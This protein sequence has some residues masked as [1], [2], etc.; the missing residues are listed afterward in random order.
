MTSPIQLDSVEQPGNVLHAGA[1]NAVLEFLDFFPTS[2]QRS[3]ATVAS[4]VCRGISVESFDEFVQPGLPRVTQLLGNTD[5]RIVDSAILCFS[6][7]VDSISGDDDKT[8]TV[9]TSDLIKIIVSL[10]S[11]SS[12]SS[13]LSGAPPASSSASS[14]AVGPSSVAMIFRMLSVAC[15]TSHSIISL[16]LQSDIAGILSTAISAGCS[17]SSDRAERAAADPKKSPKGII[18]GAGGGGVGGGGGGGGGAVESNSQEKLME[19]LGL[20]NELLPP[21][22]DKLEIAFNQASKVP[23]RELLRKKSSGGGGRV[24]RRK[25]VV[26]MADKFGPI[27]Q[28]CFPALLSLHGATTVAAVKSACTSAV[29]R[30]VHGMSP[31]ALAAMVRTNNFSGFI[32]A[33]LSGADDDAAVVYSGIRLVEGALSRFPEGESLSAFVADL[34]KEGVV[35]ELEKLARP[36]STTTPT[37]KK[38]AAAANVITMQFED[39]I[40]ECAKDVLKRFSTST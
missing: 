21:L 36:S 20:L 14:P 11:A 30:L 15:S 38:S 29:A 19:A 34:R 10:L 13:P 24:P 4:N 3:A 6:R 27:A 35:F 2:A 26:S 1:L 31:E 25:S 5:R 37:K 7:I 16:V 9:V 17:P 32:A 33:M 18:P 23:F 22:P 39:A 8:C 12:S 28:R 40:V